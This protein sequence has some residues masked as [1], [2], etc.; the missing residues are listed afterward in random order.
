MS[1]EYSAPIMAPRREAASRTALAAST[2]NLAEPVRPRI[3]GNLAHAFRLGRQPLG[4]HAFE[5][6]N[7]LPGNR[8]NRHHLGVCPHHP[9]GS[10]PTNFPT[11][12]GV[13]PHRFLGSVPSGKQ[14]TF[15][16]NYDFSR[17]ICSFL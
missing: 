1:A 15:G 5:P 10:V 12:F 2:L 4:N 14:V 8:A 16:Q 17:Q 13:C 9:L 7:P 6:L 11:D 3:A